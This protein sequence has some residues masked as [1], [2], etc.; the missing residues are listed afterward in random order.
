[1]TNGSYDVARIWSR[2]I[3]D[4]HAVPDGIAYRSKHDDDETCIA[5]FD[6]AHEHIA[7]VGVPQPIMMMDRSRLAELFALYGLGLR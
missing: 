3:H 1:M 7:T 4:H 2:V 5:L 6:R